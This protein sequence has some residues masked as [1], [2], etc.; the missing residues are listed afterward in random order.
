MCVIVD[1]YP[2]WN[3]S[4]QYQTD[5]KIFVFDRIS[6]TY[7][8]PVRMN[9][10]NFMLERVKGKF[11]R[12]TRLRKQRLWLHRERNPPDSF[13]GGANLREVGQ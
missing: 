3:F 11:E 6:Q 10:S 4:R 1:F 13:A 12:L 5:K 8:S 9:M 2:A 7:I